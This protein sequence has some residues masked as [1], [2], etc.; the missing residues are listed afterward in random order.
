LDYTSNSN[1]GSIMKGRVPESI[2]LASEERRGAEFL[3][4]IWGKRPTFV[5]TIGNTETAKIPGISAAG[6]NPAI[7]DYTPAADVELLFYGKCKCI[8]GVPV[9]PDG[10]PTPGLITM[11]A[12][13]LSKM[14]VFALNG[15]VRVRPIAPYFELDG[16]PGEDI[17]TGNAVK[18]PRKVFENAVV[19]GENLAALTDYMVVGESIAGGTTTALAVLLAQGYDAE[20]KVSSSLPVN[21]HPIKVQAAR[22]G[23]KRAKFS[24]AE[25]KEDALKAVAAVGD[26]MMPA[27]AGVIVG[28]ARKVPVI[29][30]GGT[31]MAAVLSVV[32]SV[33][34]KALDNLALGTTRWILNDKSSDLRHLV[35][36]IGPVP[37][38][39][40]NL[41][42]SRSRFDGLRIY[43]T[44]IVK[45]G[46]GCG[47]ST[48]A[49][50]CRSEGKLDAV[51]M[52]HEIDGSYERLMTKH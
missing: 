40:A 12:I 23:I 3:E 21:P 19:A 8:P 37:V 16:S 5:C 6:A 50:I 35:E 41:D 26:P 39:G 43:E 9:T 14:P 28:A 1:R 20:N 44:G 4:R 30:A 46:V 34:P 2:I 33:E 17:R 49:A 10:I 15:G 51:R 25:M 45:E 22:E 24:A 32:R 29:M 11:S 13:G 31:Q 52:L 42:F 7:T 36:Q 47:G 18:D 27:A 38:L 48:I